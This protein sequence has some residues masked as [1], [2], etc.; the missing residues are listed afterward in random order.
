MLDPIASAFG[1][2]LTLPIASMIGNGSIVLS[3]R[4]LLR[5]F[6]VPVTMFP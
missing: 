4:G 1:L 3:I 6:G 2:E 5:M